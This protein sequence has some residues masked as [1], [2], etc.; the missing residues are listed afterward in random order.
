MIVLAFL[1]WFALSIPAALILGPMIATTSRGTDW[2]T[3]V[4][5]GVMPRPR[6]CR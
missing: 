1:L 4:Q 2:P 3:P 6:V 5:R